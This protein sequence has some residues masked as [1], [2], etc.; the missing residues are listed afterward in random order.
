MAATLPLT[1]GY[2]FLAERLIAREATLEREQMMSLFASYVDPAVAETIWER[3][4]ELSLAGEERIATVMFTD[5]RGFT[6]ASSGK[7]PAQVLE[8]LNRYMTAMD[9]VIR[10]HGGFP[11]QVHWRR[12]D[13]HL[14]PAAEPGPR[15]GR[16]AGVER[17]P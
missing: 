6:A 5:I 11:Q 8:W 9:E 15:A 7:P 10:E 17:L 14:R 4:S 16:I 3:R 12:P 1:L 13:D 2:R